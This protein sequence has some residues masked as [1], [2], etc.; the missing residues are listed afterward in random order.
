MLR[1]AAAVLVSFTA[2]LASKFDSAAL[3]ALFGEGLTITCTPDPS[4][5]KLIGSL[6]TRCILVVIDGTAAHLRLNVGLLREAWRRGREAANQTR[7]YGRAFGYGMSPRRWV[8]DGE[9][10]RSLAVSKR[11]RECVHIGARVSHRLAPSDAV[12]R[13]KRGGEERVG[14][15]GIGTSMC[16]PC[17]KRCR[18]GAG[19]GWPVRQGS[20]GLLHF[21]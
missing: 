15:V 1:Q 9:S 2:L 19:E 3:L 12:V 5:F 18:R 4:F 10:R 7:S 6:I 16:L 21:L 11:G 13:I 20:R 14:G 8:R 17:G